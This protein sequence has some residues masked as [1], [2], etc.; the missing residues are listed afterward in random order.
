[1]SKGKD[2][3]NEINYA[4]LLENFFSNPSFFG[5]KKKGGVVRS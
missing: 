1:M 5:E 3:S 4:L 2:E